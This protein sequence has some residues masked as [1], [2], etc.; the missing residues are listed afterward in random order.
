MTYHRKDKPIDASH[1]T[2]SM[3]TETVTQGVVH[4]LHATLEQQLAT[5]GHEY[6][7]H[8]RPVITT[9]Y[10]HPVTM[11][12]GGEDEDAEVQEYYARPFRYLHPR[13]D[14]QGTLLSIAFDTQPD[15]DITTPNAY[16]IRFVDVGGRVTLR[17]ETAELPRDNNPE[18]IRL[19]QSLVQQFL[20][21]GAEESADR[22]SQA[23]ERHRQRMNAARIGAWSVT[24]LAAVVAIV[25]GGIA[26][27]DNVAESL[28][29]TGQFDKKDKALT[30]GTQIEL[31]HSGHPEFSDD[32]YADP[33]LEASDIPEMAVDDPDDT[34][35]PDD[36]DPDDTLRQLT[37]TSSEGGKNTAEADIDSEGIPRSARLVAWTDFAD[38]NGTSRADELT[39]TYERDTVT[40][41]W[42]GQERNDDDDPRVVVALIPEEEATPR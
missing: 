36:L 28:D 26:V 2:E 5:N 15:P 29:K 11:R 30:G 41:E 22:Q 35:T 38:E 21:D 3:T 33:D 42:E 39:V 9:E 25:W 4:T 8:G 34:E 10:Y 23:R 6:H 37:V 40:V 13:P 1:L 19:V 32:L 14:E 12:L 31:G 18:D 7:L 24:G 20:E 17:V 16:W 27:L